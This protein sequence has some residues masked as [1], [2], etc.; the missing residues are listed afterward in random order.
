MNMHTKHAIAC[1][2]LKLYSI[3]QFNGYTHVLFNAT[4]P[5]AM[6][7]TCCNALTQC[8]KDNV[9]WLQCCT[10][11]PSLVQK[12]EV[13]SFWLDMFGL[14]PCVFS[15]LPSWNSSKY[16]CWMA[17]LATI[18]L[19]GLNVSIFWNKKEHTCAKD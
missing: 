4:H 12:A 18:L 5:H 9:T 2:A 14:L 8:W 15:L 3:M 6:Q 17:C 1:N 11:Q 13:F 16:S 19:F 7:Y 10:L